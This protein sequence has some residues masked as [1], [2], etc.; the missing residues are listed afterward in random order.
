MMYDMLTIIFRHIYPQYN[1][2]TWST[3]DEMK[4][5]RPADDVI[6]AYYDFAQGYFQLLAQAIPEVSEV[7]SGKTPAKAVEKHRI[8]SGG[9][10][11]FRPLGQRMFAQLVAE[12][13]K[14]YQ[15]EDIFEWLSL[16]PTRLDEPPYANVIWD[17]G[18]QTMTSSKTDASIVRDILLYMLQEKTRLTTKALNNRYAQYFGEESSKVEL[19]SPVVESE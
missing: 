2:V 6:E 15:L 18:T 5:E 1:E 16:L 19:P 8:D 17:T 10:V 7:L 3:L 9:S 13:S 11:L 4:H 14:S 12:L